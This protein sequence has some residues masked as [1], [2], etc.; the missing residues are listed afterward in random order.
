MS[1]QTPN[2]ESDSTES[3]DNS[4]FVSRLE[5]G[6]SLILDGDVFHV[7]GTWVPPMF[8]FPEV[9]GIVNGR[10]ESLVVADTEVAYRSDYDEDSESFDHKVM[11]DQVSVRS[12]DKTGVVEAIRE[13]SLTVTDSRD[14]P[15][16]PRGKIGTFRGG[17]RT[18]DTAVELYK[19]SGEY[20]ITA[21]TDEE[22][23][24]PETWYAFVR[25]F[26]EPDTATVTTKMW[27][28]DP[29][30]V[31]ISG[32]FRRE[33]SGKHAALAGC[34]G[35]HGYWSASEVAEFINPKMDG[36]AFGTVR[37]RLGSILWRDNEHT[38]KVKFKPVTDD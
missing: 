9:Y 28:S 21:D 24:G 7:V 26:P 22:R 37:E 32:V 30:T 11:M 10:R 1:T 23:Y 15:I 13:S 29:E 33:D 17:F 19:D 38:A 18:P 2:S 12:G 8:A 16:H 31:E 36:E 6:D 14:S 3:V 5:A 4:D 35:F 34:G 20:G 27:M 25:P